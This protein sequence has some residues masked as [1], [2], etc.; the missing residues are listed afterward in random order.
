MIIVA[1]LLSGTASF[2][3]TIPTSFSTGATY[4][5]TITSATNSSCKDSS[6]NYFSF[7]P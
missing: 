2:R 7:A 5:I 4:Q 1:F 3:W 6:D